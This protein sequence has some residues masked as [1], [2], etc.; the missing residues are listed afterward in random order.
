VF[1]RIPDARLLR[2]NALLVAAIA[3]CFLPIFTGCGTAQ[4]VPADATSS[5]GSTPPVASPGI[6]YRKTYD[7]TVQYAANDVVTYLRST[8]IAL[9]SAKN[10][11]PTGSSQSA[12]K[13]SLLAGAGQ[14]GTPGASGSQGASGPQ[15]PTGPAGP[16]GKQGIAGQDRTSFLAGRRF[17]VLGDSISS[18][19]T[20]GGEWQKIVAN[21]TGLVA[22]YT[23]AVSGRHLYQ[24]FSCYG[25][26]HPG[27]PLG[28]YS[29]AIPGC[30]T[31]GGKDGATLAEN[32]ADS[33][34]AIIALG[35]ND[36]NVP[37]GQLGD[38]PTSGTSEGTLRWIV[39]TIEMANPKIRVVIVTPQMN[40]LGV[41]ANIRLLSDAEEEYGGSAGIPVVNMF[42]LSGV[43]S[44]N[45]STLTRDGIHPTPWAFDNFYGPVIA[46][47]LM[48]IF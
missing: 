42:R 43:N 39:E 16:Q 22:T 11:P 12:A 21:R 20:S 26:N 38:D 5:Q 27:D 25:V 9:A 37:I 48:Q 7:P 40:T 46:Q 8:Y 23:D 32:L 2:S 33:D 15:G 30:L 47:H 35:T 29:I 14:D 36:E 13:W 1:R 3:L 10:I 34:L 28:T 17:F 31:Y 24:A 4:A 19:S 41:A 6:V 44:T 18:L 45:L